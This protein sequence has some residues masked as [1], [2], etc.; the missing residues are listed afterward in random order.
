[1]ALWVI[2]EVR[3]GRMRRPEATKR[4]HGSRL[5]IG[6]SWVAALLLASVARSRTPAAAFPDGAVTFG[7]GLAIIWAGIAL[8]WWSIHRLGR[9]FTFDVMTS[10]DQR[11][12]TSG[13]YRVLRHPGYAGLLLV[14]IGIGV[15]YANWLSLAALIVLPLAG[16]TYRIRVEETALSATLGESYRAYASGRKRIIPFVW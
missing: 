7:T 14:F 15:L 12:I 6:V 10:A 4:D 13:P 1:M 16:L 8:R 2:I 3:Q 5:L 11:V 9:Y